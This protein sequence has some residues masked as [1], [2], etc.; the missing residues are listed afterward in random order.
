MLKKIF[1][2]MFIGILVGCFSSKT[3]AENN[4]GEVISNRYFSLTV[5]K[6]VK[7]MYKTEKMDKGIYICEKIST[8]S[9]EG[10]FAFALKIYREPKDYA[11]MEKVRKIGEL[12]DKKGTIY[13]MVLIRP[14]EIRY[15]EGKTIEENYSRLYKLGDNIEINGVNGYKYFKNQGVKGE[16]LYNEIL[17][18]YKTAMENNWSSPQFKDEGLGCIYP[19]LSKSTKKL[20]KKIGYTYYDINDDGI[21]EL[22][23]GEISEGKSKGIIYDIYTMVDRKPAHV[24]SCKE[25]EKFFVCDDNFIWNEYPPERSEK[26]AGVF[27]LKN[28][29]TEIFP[30]VMF[31]YDTKLNK[32][33]P[34]FIS[35]GRNGNLESVSQQVFNERKD[36]FTEFKK[37]DYIP[38]NKFDK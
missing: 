2:I 8:K 34:W 12:V 11:D 35:Y 20:L 10:G 5:P 29:S 24:V 31:I 15:G 38:L 14:T 33:T 30:K 9:G 3:F 26:I 25:K 19:S 16:N 22:I 27:I 4:S 23:I 1:I 6:E 13:D 37:F 7:N 21:D 28:N 32:K 18:K 36:L 17:K